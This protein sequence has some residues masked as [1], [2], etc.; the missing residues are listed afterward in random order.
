MSSRAEISQQ[1]DK[2]YSINVEVCQEGEGLFQLIEASHPEFLNKK[3][4]TKKKRLNVPVGFNKPEVAE[5][6]RHRDQ[7]HIPSRSTS[8]VS[9]GSFGH[10]HA[11]PVWT[12]RSEPETEKKSFL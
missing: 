6:P 1:G 4:K 9:G 12:Q 7:N 10:V 3:K 8:S 5:G 2:T 11:P